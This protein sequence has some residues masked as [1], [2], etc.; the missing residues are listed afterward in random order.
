MRAI[1]SIIL[2]CGSL[3][4][5]FPDQNESLLALRAI[6]DCNIPKFTTK[7]VPLFEALMSDLFPN[8]KEEERDY[9]ELTKQIRQYSED[10]CYTLSD[11]FLFL[12]NDNNCSWLDLFYENNRTV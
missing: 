5:T 2:A 1:K 10:N 6:N 11:V 8:T 12:I 9:G 7:D 3:K 4:R